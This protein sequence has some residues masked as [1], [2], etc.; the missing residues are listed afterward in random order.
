MIAYALSSMT[1]G[2]AGLWATTFVTKALK[3]TPPNFR[4]YNNFL[5]EFKTSF[6]QENAQDQAITW[7]TNT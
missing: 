2:A 3:T 4:S 5:N 6:I 1:E 7:M